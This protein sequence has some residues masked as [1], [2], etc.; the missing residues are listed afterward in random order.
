LYNAKLQEN[1]ETI[2][3]AKA[4]CSPK[5]CGEEKEIKYTIRCP[6]KSYIY[7]IKIPKNKSGPH[8]I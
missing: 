6:P 4:Y 2:V 8:E 5:D 3:K 7:I 1:D